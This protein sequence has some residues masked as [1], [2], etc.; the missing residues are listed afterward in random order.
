MRKRIL[1]VEDEPDNQF[2]LRLLFEPRHDVFT[3]SDLAT[4]EAIYQRE[5]PID[6]VILDHLLPDGWGL[7]FCRKLKTE[8]DR[9]PILFVTGLTQAL[10]ELRTCG[11]DVVTKPFDPDALHEQVERLLHGQV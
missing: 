11:D 3:A 5:R 9:P 1:I 4:A 8:R 6:L 7:D 10:E 2:I